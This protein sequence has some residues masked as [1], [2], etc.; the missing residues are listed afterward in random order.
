MILK[1]L[2][3][4]TAIS[5]SAIAP[6]ANTGSAHAIATPVSSMNLIVNGGFEDTTLTGTNQAQLTGNST[7]NIYDRINGWSA[8]PN[9]KIEVQRGGIAGSPHKDISDPNNAYDRNLVELDSHGY[10]KTKFSAENPLGIYQD[11]ATVVGQ[12]YTLSFDYSARPNTS[13]ANNIFD[14]LVGDVANVGNVLRERISIGAGGQTTAWTTFTRTFI[15]TS[16]LSRVQFNYTP[17]DLNTGL[18][19]YGSYI[20]DVKLVT[21]NV[22]EVPEPGAMAGIVI[23]GLGLVTFKKRSA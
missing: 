17:N 7:W 12:T 1:K 23:A 16:Q 22:A 2:V 11:V 9:G 4:A 6:F 10:D 14:V 5:V 19:T 21:A 8:T 3:C 13:A 18:D 15:A 20:D